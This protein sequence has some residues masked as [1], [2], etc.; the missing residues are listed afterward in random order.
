M[1]EILG[2]SFTSGEVTQEEKV[3]KGYV[4]YCFKI[5]EIPKMFVEAKKTSNPLDDENDLRQAITYALYRATTWAIITNFKRTRIFNAEVSGSIYQARVM[6]IY[7]EN[8][9]SDFD[10]LFLLSKEGFE[11]GLLD[12]YAEKVCKK[13]TK[14]AIETQLFRDLNSWRDHLARDIKKTY[15][16]EYNAEIIDEMIQTLL[17]RFI[18]IRKIEDAN[19]ESKRLKEAYNLWL[20]PTNKKS[21]WHHIKGV[22]AYYD[23]EYDSKIFDEKKNELDRI[24]ISD[25][26]LKII[27]PQLYTSTD[28]T[29]EYNFELIPANILGNIYEQYLGNI[30]KAT[31][32]R[33]KITNGSANRKEQ[34]IYY[35][36]TY[37]VDYIIDNTLGNLL[38]EYKTPQDVEKIKVIDPACGSGS[39]LI[40]AFDE[41]YAWFENNGFLGERYLSVGSHK[42]LETAKDRIIKEN[43]F[44]VDLDSKAV[45]IAQLNLLL[46]TADKRH[47]LPYLK[48]N[49]KQGNSLI[50][51]RDATPHPFIW[52]REFKEIWE[53]GKFDVVIGNPPYVNIQTLPELQKWCEKKY[54]EIYTGQ[55]DILYYFVFVGLNI[56]RNNGK[57]GF[58][59]SR[60]FL[61]SSY[62]SKFRKFILEQ[63][64]IDSIIDFNNFQVFGR[65]VNVLTSII[66]LTKGK[67]SPSAIIKVIKIKDWEKSGLELMSHILK[68]A[69]KTTY[70]DEYIDI[71]RISQKDLTEESWTLSNP[72]INEIKEK[73]EEN[74]QALSEICNIGQGMTTGL[75]EAFVVDTETAVKEKIEREVLRNYIKTRD[76]K[77]YVSLNRDLKIIYIP[78]KTDE[79]K[80]M[81]TINY[82]KRWEKELKQRYDYI[83]GHCEWYSWG[84][85]RNR[86]FFENEVEKIITPLYSTSN[87]FI[88]DSGKDDQNYCTLTDTYLIVPKEKSL[89]LKYVLAILNS[90]L[91]EFYFKNTGKLKREG[92]YEYSGGALH[93]IP[94]KYDKDFSGKVEQL[95]NNILSLKGRL[96]EIGDKQ[97]NERQ[98]IE[99]DIERIEKDVDEHVYKIYGI[100]EDEKKIIEESLK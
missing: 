88:Y 58:I 38:R 65:D 1:F 80:I 6:D 81:N 30:L 39:F 21:L 16:K 99:D 37:V 51:D 83:K 53:S 57:L 82:L 45:E 98:K 97:T 66:I 72:R 48:E 71:F 26:P 85:L 11:Q 49:I 18:L 10:N 12:K 43:L 87:K 40:G 52:E 50:D 75:N 73:L 15:E 28:Q 31:N 55:N 56:L 62:A 24:E 3:S 77:R 96:N 19:L 44:G 29:I 2:W 9:L 46:K 89:N 92:Y 17:D 35:T 14:R 84:N 69:D 22:F 90:R 20:S 86:E 61:E 63:S 4:D 42:I 7:L 91:I 8:Y 100:T 5:N 78:D 74:S 54:P 23:V 41:L 36:P 67:P 27:L 34:G 64:A 93:K 33:T 32:K 13:A 95:V 59:T 25:Y 68:N 79:N 94:I 76:L 47:Q 60:Y 70:S